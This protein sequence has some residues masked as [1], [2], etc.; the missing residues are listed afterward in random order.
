MFSSKG[1]LKCPSPNYEIIQPLIK[2][3][4]YVD[5]I[6]IASCVE[7]NWYA[8]ETDRDAEFAREVFISR[9][10]YENKDYKECWHE[11]GQYIT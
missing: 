1:N 5:K 7:A 11:D 6:L 9:I 8:F 2:T 4:I 10:Y 3:D